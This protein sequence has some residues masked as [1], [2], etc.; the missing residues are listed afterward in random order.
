MSDAG[1]AVFNDRYE[2]HNSIGRGGMADVFLARDRLLDRAVAVKVLFPEFAT[3]PNFVE[4]FRREAQA[5]AN[6]NH[7]NIVGVYD[8]G[9]QGGTYFIV[10]EYVNGRSLA[11]IL[12]AQGAIL[13]ER[14]ADVASEVAA[15][16]S[17]AHQNG[18]V[19]RDIKPANILVSPQGAVKVADF[20][21]ARALNTPTDENLTQAGSVMGT[22]TYFS[23]EQ[24]Q[25]NPLDQRSDLY[26]LGIV[27][28][29]MVTGKAPFGGD[30]PVAIA[31]KQV[32]DAPPPIYE[33]AAGVPES[34]Q[35]I[36][37]KLLAKSPAQRYHDAD[38][39]RADLRRF[40]EGRP[41][42]AGAPIAQDDITIAAPRAASAAVDP[43]VVAAAYGTNVGATRSMP[44]QTRSQPI[45]PP[46]ADDPRAYG[47]PPRRIGVFILAFLV[48]IAAVIG[49]IFALYKGLNNET[50]KDTTVAVAA[51]EN[52]PVDDAVTELKRQGL[53]PNTS[54]VERADLQAGIV[55]KQN[56]A[57]GTQALPN[58]IVN[59]DVS[60]RPLVPI[61][62]IVGL[63]QKD[64]DKA[65]RD[66]NLVPDFKSVEDPKT[67]I[68]LVASQD[69]VAGQ[70]VAEG[71]KITVNL[72]QGP[73]KTVVPAVT[74]GA[75]PDAVAADL[76]KA[77]LQSKVT[78]QSSDTIAIDK[79]ITTN[80]PPGSSLDKNSVV[81]ILVS[82]G[83]ELVE[84]PDLIGTTEA[85]A[86]TQLQAKGFLQQVVNVLVAD[87]AQV[88]KVVGQ[89]P[90]PGDKVKA[91]SRVTIQVGTAPATTL[92][93]TTIVVP[94]TAAT[95]T[96]PPTT[97]GG[98][99]TSGS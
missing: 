45:P 53:V 3:D 37:S 12:R 10:M 28:Y 63:S 69:P 59:L 43:T 24:A 86:R 8:W 13:P 56:P 61:P 38:D 66:A 11:D 19:H 62:S 84:V 87:P 31:Y 76:T 14:A 57:A 47:E 75:D 60:T 79:V 51:V 67:Q 73:G 49:L 48:T 72:S 6:L 21:I 70:K 90:N 93:P 81:T 22:A 64:A 2:I 80:P 46:V 1:R 36:V 35:S 30:N 26:S 92:P 32:H 34:Y 83:P 99:T 91:G 71:T 74:P 4:R 29:E 85:D 52:M 95:T 25:G 23:P 18:V 65:L 33:L 42:V 41:V 82:T 97:T 68:G 5:A 78:K 89:S 39:L 96:K 20:G 15:A 54:L 55:V 9:R 17:F 88:G 94:T 98:A 40:K 16:L 58:A 44:A 7:P 77:G 50:P 27:M